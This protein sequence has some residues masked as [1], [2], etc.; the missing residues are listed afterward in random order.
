ML[1]ISCPAGSEMPMNHRKR[2][3][4]KQLQ[5]PASYL[6]SHYRELN[7]FTKT[8]WGGKANNIVCDCT[9]PLASHF[10]LLLSGR[11]FCLPPMTKNITKF[12]FVPQAIKA[13]NLS[14]L[15]RGPA[16]LVIPKGLWCIVV[17][18]VC[19]SWYVCQCLMYGL[20][21]LC[22]MSVLS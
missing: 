4:E 12:S 13:L 18:D 17:C 21:V 11:R 8:D 20:F 3:S 5:L 10:K 1:G 9:H 15:A 7:P 14:K 22:H 19:A 16:G 6:G 2:Q